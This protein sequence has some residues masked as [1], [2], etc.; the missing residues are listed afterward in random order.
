MSHPCYNVPEMLRELAREIEESGVPEQYI[1][2]VVTERLDTAT[3][4]VE[5]YGYGRF[6]N[7]RQTLRL[8]GKGVLFMA[9]TLIDESDDAD[10]VGEE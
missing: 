3:D 4:E 5:V 8:F 1:C 2:A 10:G 9:D 6:S 7:C